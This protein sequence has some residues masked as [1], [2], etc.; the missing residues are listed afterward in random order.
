MTREHS[1]PDAENA[2]H[3]HLRRLSTEFFK[4]LIYINFRVLYITPV[5]W[6]PSRRRAMAERFH[7]SAV[8]LILND[9]CDICVQ[10]LL[11]TKANFLTYPSADVIEIC[12][13]ADKFIKIYMHDN[14]PLNPLLI[15]SNILASF[16]NNKNI[17]AS[18]GYHNIQNDHQIM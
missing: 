13:I 7:E 10:A 6:T 11:G 5:F 3:H 17:F 16:I 18:I 4:I 2:H 14:K 1:F 8:V 15:Q 9:I 12:L